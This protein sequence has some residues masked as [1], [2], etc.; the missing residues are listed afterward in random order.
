MGVGTSIFLIAVGAVLD[1]AVKVNNSNF[2]V[3]TIGVILMAVGA[4][5]LVLSLVFWGSWGG[6]GNYRRSQ[7]VVHDGNQ[8]Y[9]EERGRY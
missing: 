2:N 5:G 1:F 7:R 6:F 9:V 8:T 3:N 4:L